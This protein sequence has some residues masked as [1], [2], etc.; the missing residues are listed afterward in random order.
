MLKNITRRGAWLGAAALIVMTAGPAT[1]ADPQAEADA[2]ALTATGALV[3]EGGLDLNSDECRAEIPGGNPAGAGVCGHGINT[4]ENVDAFAQEAKA[5]PDGTNCQAFGGSSADDM[6]GNEN[7]TPQFVHPSANDMSCAVASATPVH[8]TGLDTIST[9]DLV[10]NGLS[11]IQTGTVLDSIVGPVGT[12]RDLLLQ[13]NAGLLTQIDNAVKGITVPLNQNLPVQLVIDDVASVCAATTSAARGN[14]RVGSVALNVNLGGQTSVDVPF[15]GPNDLDT[16]PNTPLVGG[17]LVPLANAIFDGLDDTLG[18]SLNGALDPI[19]L[20]TDQIQAAI[21]N[22]VLVTLQNSLLSQLDDALS[23]LVQ[24][25]VNKQVD[26]H[27]SNTEVTYTSNATREIEVA[28]LDLRLLQGGGEQVAQVLQLGR[29]HCGPN[30]AGDGN[31]GGPGLQVLKTEKVK[32]KSKVEWTIQVHNPLG[33]AVDD[34]LVKDFYPKAVKGDVEVTEGPSQGTFNVDTGIWDV[35][36][37]QPNATAT[38][39]IEAKVSKSKLDD[40]INNVACV[41][42]DPNAAKPDKV[43][44]N[45]TFEDDTDGCDDSKS[46]KKKKKNGNGHD[47]TPK[48]IDS[49]MN[50]GGN[51]GALAIAGLVAASTLAGTASRQRLL[52]NR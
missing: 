30:S 8:V 31:G 45:K 24:G 46:K 9:A 19:V 37:L 12:A 50:D 21:V 42:D 14:S 5:G 15:T 52:L 32:G 1:A 38:L 13:N 40:G 48:T 3:G 7:P 16:P 4:V 41:V 2:S 47:D 51:L 33:E 34:V 10:T 27:N 49:G 20:L 35:G 17:S 26:G 23:P 25:V 43:Q 39:K 44:S 29:V 22:Q 18:N 6:Y 28:A 36:T 11:G